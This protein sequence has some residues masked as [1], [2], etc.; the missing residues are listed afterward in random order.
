M[1]SSDVGHYL[2]TIMAQVRCL[3][4]NEEEKKVY[5]SHPVSTAPNIADVEVR[6]E[7]V[8]KRK[9][10]LEKSNVLNVYGV[11]GFKLSSK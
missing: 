7:C 8:K 10:V 11:L 9:P 1:P 3:V 5:I 4:C 2:Q 6:K